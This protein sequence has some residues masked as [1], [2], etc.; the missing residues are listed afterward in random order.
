MK[1]TIIVLAAMFVAIS[2]QAKITVFNASDAVK[3]ALNNEEVASFLAHD[4]SEYGGLTLGEIKIDAETTGKSKSWSINFYLVDSKRKSV[5]FFY[6]E[7]ESKIVKNKLPGG[8][9]ITSSKL[10][11]TAVEPPECHE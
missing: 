3:A 1:K 6:S 5:C 8:A 11:V 4:Y 10:E 9:I 2:A 7:V